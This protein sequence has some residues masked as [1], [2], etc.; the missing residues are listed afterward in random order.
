MIR[1]RLLGLASVLAASSGCCWWAD[2]MCPQHC[3]PTTAYQPV[4]CQPYTPPPCQPYTPCAPTTPGYPTASSA[5]PA[6]GAWQPTGA[7]KPAGCP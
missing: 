1:M 6:A 5:A 7:V 2:K 4:A 3:C